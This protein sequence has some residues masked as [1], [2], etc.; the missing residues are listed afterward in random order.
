MTSGGKNLVVLSDKIACAVLL[1]AF[2]EAFFKAHLSDHEFFARPFRQNHRAAVE[3]APPEIRI[4]FR[5]FY[6]GVQYFGLQYRNIR[7]APHI[8][9]PIL[10]RQRKTFARLLLHI[11]N[12]ERQFLLFSLMSR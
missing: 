6:E 5:T 7:Y 4:S 11:L 12:D 9:R 2:F 3:M 8:R 10:P 1:A